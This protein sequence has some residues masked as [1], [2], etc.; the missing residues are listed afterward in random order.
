MFQTNTHPRV[1]LHRTA[2]FA[3]NPGLCKARGAITLTA[4]GIERLYVTTAP[5]E[6]TSA[7]VLNSH[8]FRRVVRHS[9]A[10]TDATATDKNAALQ[11]TPAGHPEIAATLNGLT[12]GVTAVLAAAELRTCPLVIVARMPPALTTYAPPVHLASPV[13][14]SSPNSSTLPQWTQSRTDYYAGNNIV[15]EG[16]TLL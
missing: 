2:R 6:V 8:Y 15:G 11:L 14:P 3:A 13:S 5:T 16:N 12:M 7:L 10:S 9:F 4:P 1:I